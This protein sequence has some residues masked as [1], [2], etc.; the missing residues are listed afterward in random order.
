MNQIETI[1]RGVCI[2]DGK[3]LLCHPRGRA[4]AYLPGGHIEFGETGR[5][6]LVREIEEEMGLKAKAGELIDVVESSFEQKG[7]KHC[8]INLVYR[9]A[10]EEIPVKPE[11]SE[12]WIEFS[13]CP[14]EAL[15]DAGFKP[16][17]MLRVL[18]GDSRICCM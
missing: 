2:V 17:E 5:E 11:A 9:L 10:F 15:D 14:L 4:Y 8:E 1:A 6:A 13:W 12:E 16:E 18:K 3:V 7:E